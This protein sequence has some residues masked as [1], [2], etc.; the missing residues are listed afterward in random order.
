MGEGQR[1]KE[2]ENPKRSPY[3]EYRARLGLELM[4]CE[5][6]TWAKIKSQMLN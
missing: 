3:Y 1:E 6:M 5:I 4:N 2:R